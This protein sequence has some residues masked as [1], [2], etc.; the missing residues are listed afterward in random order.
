[1]DKSQTRT[2]YLVLAHHNEGHFKRNVTALGSNGARVFAHIDKKADESRFETPRVEYVRNR[3]DVRWGGWSMVQATLNLMHAAAP[4]VTDKD[5]VVLL[6]GDSYPLQSQRSIDEFLPPAEDGV[7]YVNMLPFP[8]PIAEKPLNRVSRLY[9]EYDP[10]SGRANLAPR[11][12][13]KLK[14]P[15]PY[16]RALGGRDMYCGSQW[17]ALTGAAFH[18]LLRESRKAS[19]FNSMC[20]RMFVPDEFYFQTLLGQCP[21]LS[22]VRRNLIFADWYRPV[23]PRPSIIDSDHVIQ[24]SRPGGLLMEN[25][26]YAAGPAL[27]ARKFSD[28]SEALT[29]RIRDEV[30]PNRV[31]AS[32]YETFEISS[33]QLHVWMGLP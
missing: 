26:G 19:V 12:I 7:Q 5:Y 33:K 15:R 6:S 3:V 16:R 4:T 18:W 1:M 2:V 31:P 20:R 32:E 13:N 25:R 9:V 24:L 21:Y 8:S 30:W 11:V 10:R 14:I 23:G 22:E 17:W 28:D 29:D 27:F